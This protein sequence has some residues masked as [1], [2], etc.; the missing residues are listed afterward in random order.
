M[1]NSTRKEKVTKSQAKRARKQALENPVV[2]NKAISTPATPVEQINKPEEIKSRR[3]D[4]PAVDMTIPNQVNSTKSNAD[5]IAP[6]VSTPLTK[7]SLETSGVLPTGATAQKQA[8]IINKGEKP[9]KEA[10][11]LSPWEQMLADRREALKQE[12]TDAAKMQKYYALADSLKALGKMGATAIGG[13]IGGNALDSATTVGEYKASRGYI[14]AFEK[15]KQANEAL[16]KLDDT[17]F[18]LAY[19]KAQR[20][21]DRAYNEKM[22]AAE[23]KYRTDM[24]ML[25]HELRKAEKAEDREWEER[26]KKDIL[27]LTQSFEREMKDKSLEIVR[28]Q[29]GVDSEEKKDS[30]PFTFQNLTKVDIPK[31]LYP[32]LINWAISLGQIG[33]DYVDAENAE[34]V[35]RKHP[36]LVNSFLN[37]Y[38]LGA[39]PETV[40]VTSNTGVVASNKK[41]PS[42]VTSVTSEQAINAGN[43]MPTFRTQ[44]EKEARKEERIRK[45][46]EKS[47][48]KNAAKIAASREHLNNIGSNNEYYDDD[49]ALKIAG[50]SIIN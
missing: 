23:R 1:D 34:I 43:E 13:A 29:M 30:I 36:E 50:V 12:K 19:S 49:D 26:V 42:N 10:V 20:D 45:A 31:N 14:D 4:L 40:E 2:E 17:E 24:M 38:G 22:V 25:E 39:K 48:A 3:L 21:E 35:L 33:N 7:G 41:N 28:M 44:S 9:Y 5:I 27:K 8:T 18:Q 15:A 11:V 47:M 32:E 37:L 16:R 46:I 6:S